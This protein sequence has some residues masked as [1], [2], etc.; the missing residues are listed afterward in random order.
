VLNKKLSADAGVAKQTAKA[1]VKAVTL[2]RVLMVISLF[3]WVSA[4][5]ERQRKRYQNACHRE[6]NIK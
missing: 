1:N 5:A 6:V 2:I 4:E 3:E